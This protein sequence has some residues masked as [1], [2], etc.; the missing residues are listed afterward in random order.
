MRD[1]KKSLTTD[2]ILGKITKEPYNGPNGPVIT[3]PA[4]ILPDGFVAACH[5]HH[6]VRL[7]RTMD[8][9]VKHNRELHDYRKL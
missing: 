3:T 4:Y 7:F 5:L 9:I 8:E 1:K 2:R 6:N